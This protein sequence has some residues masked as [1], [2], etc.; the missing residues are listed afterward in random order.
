MY[1]AN[2]HLRDDLNGL[3]SGKFSEI[4]N[5]IATPHEFSTT[6]SKLLLSNHQSF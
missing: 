2:L 5:N 1:E 4:L 6:K 3:Y